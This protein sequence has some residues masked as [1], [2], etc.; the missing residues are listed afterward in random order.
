MVRKKNTSDLYWFGPKNALRP[1]GEGSLV[2]SSTE[3]LVVGGYKR[4]REG[5]ASRSQDVSGV[6]VFAPD[7][8]NGLWICL[9]SFLLLERSLPAPFIV[10]RRCR[11]TKCL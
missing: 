6:C 3:V 5:G 8:L 7:E 10:S 4:V 1:V 11:V 9:L 2:L